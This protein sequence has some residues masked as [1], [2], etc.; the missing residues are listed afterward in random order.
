MM[1][2]YTLEITTLSDGCFGSGEGLAGLVDLETAYERDTGLPIISGKTIKGLIVEAA[3]DLLYTTQHLQKENRWQQKAN[4]L[5]GQPGAGSASGNNLLRIGNA[6]FPES[7][8]NALLQKFQ[9]Q[10]PNDIELSP[11]E[12]LESL[13]SIRRQTAMD[14]ETGIPDA[15]SL[16]SQ[17]LVLRDTNFFA[18]VDMTDDSDALALFCA[19]ILS[20]HRG[21]SGR[22]RGKGRLKMRLLDDGQEITKGQA[23]LFFKS[24]NKEDA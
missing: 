6:S 5:F 10:S 16:R 1:K 14:D 15:G 9:S 3:G 21:G 24:F 23:E 2:N 13:T 7:I 22:N 18:R 11:P 17:R 12:V 19:C 4:E 20:I 8:G